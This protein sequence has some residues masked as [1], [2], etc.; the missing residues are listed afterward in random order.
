MKRKRRYGPIISDEELKALK[1]RALESLVMYIGDSKD[2]YERLLKLHEK[3]GPERFVWWLIMVLDMQR[4]RGMEFAPDPRLHPKLG[5]KLDR[6]CGASWPVD[7]LRG[8]RLGGMC[9]A[10][11]LRIELP[12]DADLKE[13][14]RAMQ[15]YQE[16]F[17]SLEPHKLLVVYLADEHGRGRTYRELTLE[18]NQ[19]SIAWANGETPLLYV[20]LGLDAFLKRRGYTPED[21]KLDLESLR[22]TDERK[23]VLEDWPFNKDQVR[24]WVR[25]YLTG[26]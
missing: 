17:Q 16:Y 23:A 21:I 7:E 9:E 1:Q 5:E 15:T 24:V 18:L 26:E 10:P 4:H 19:A 20:C 13:Y 22:L 2:R 12:L 3:M 8:S 6:L 25:Y 14:L 11:R